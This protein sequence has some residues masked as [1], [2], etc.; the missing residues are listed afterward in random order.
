M[1]AFSF[2]CSLKSCSI[3]DK[4]SY[5]S[6]TSQKK[7]SITPSLSILSFKLPSTALYIFFESLSIFLFFNWVCFSLKCEFLSFIS[8]LVSLTNSVLILSKSWNSS[9][10]LF[11]LELHAPAALL[12]DI[13]A[14]DF[15]SFKSFKEWKYF[16]KWY[17]TSCFD[18]VILY[19]LYPW[20]REKAFLVFTNWTWNYKSIIFSSKNR[21][22][23]NQFLLT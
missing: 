23:N 21:F 14:R 10:K 19:C 22:W 6:P 2:F 18:E 20:R 1:S 3:L 16:S 13:G 17:I 15:S 9:Q 7:E 11:S 8:L 4:V 5:N 12:G